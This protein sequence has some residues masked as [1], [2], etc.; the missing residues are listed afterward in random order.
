[1]RS[2]LA[3]LACTLAISLSVVSPALPQ[4][5][6]KLT[7]GDKD[8]GKPHSPKPGHL[9]AHGRYEVAAGHADPLVVV[10][11]RK[12]GQNGFEVH[13]AL[14]GNGGWEFKKELPAGTYEVRVRLEAVRLKSGD[15]LE[16]TVP[17]MLAKPDTIEVVVK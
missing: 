8:Q 16:V 9:A 15:K 5:P 7:F 3:I 4:E 2:Q 11:I 17:D 12:K 1:M 10:L 6:L 13:K 14:T